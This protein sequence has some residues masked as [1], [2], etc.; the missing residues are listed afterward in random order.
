MVFGV[1]DTTKDSTLSQTGVR[2]RLLIGR[3]TLEVGV[4]L[5]R[6]F[7]LHYGLLSQ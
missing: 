7:L 1:T 3:Q 4:R 2:I 5:R 6:N